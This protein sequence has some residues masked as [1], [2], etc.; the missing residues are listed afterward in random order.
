MKVIAVAISAVVLS[1]CASQ[2]IGPPS[3]EEMAAWQKLH[4]CYLISAQQLDDRLSD[5][6]TV[7]L[8]VMGKCRPTLEQLQNTVAGS[9]YGAY[10]EGL[11]LGINQSARDGALEVVLRNRTKSS[12]Q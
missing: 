1:G 8:G 3:P 4:D 7:A 5:A 11:L 9:T 6:R 10:R 12:P 2:D